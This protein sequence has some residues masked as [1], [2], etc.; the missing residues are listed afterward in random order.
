MSKVMLII[1]PSSGKELGK[2][3]AEFAE[4]T[5]AQRF[6][7]VDVRFTEKELDATQ[8]AKQAA[9]ER[10]DA[11][12]AMGGDGTVNE[13]ITGIAEQDY[14][15][16]LGIVP[17]GTVNDLA[18]ALNIPTDPQEAI[19]ILEDAPSRPL[20]IGK[21]DDHYF[22]NVI[23]V[24]LIAEAV[25]EVSVEQKTSL[26]SVA[27][28]I[29]GLKAFKDHSPYPIQLTATEKSFDGET[30]LLIISLTNSVGGFESFAKEAR[31][32][33]GL[34]HVFIIKQLGFFDA[35]QALPKL[36]T[37]GIADADQVDYFTTKEVRIDSKEHLPINADGDTAGHLPITV[38]VL[39][40]HLTVFAP[41]SN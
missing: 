19:S 39:S 36:L 22:M 24:G 38:Q 20:D 31:V 17:L 2:K 21:Y 26:G 40:Q 23:A 3:H 35:L 32:D 15:P 34:L 27:Y 29:E 18:R 25:E 16:T 11:V 30:P 14:R 13:V 8:F 5:L 41:V 28:F 6:T 7:E 33:D 4:G 37:G 12:V 1:N 9:Q 10:Y